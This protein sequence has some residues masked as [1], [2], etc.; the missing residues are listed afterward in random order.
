MNARTN[1]IIARG[2]QVPK[3]TPINPDYTQ[4]VL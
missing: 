4:M 2:V 1:K 3:R